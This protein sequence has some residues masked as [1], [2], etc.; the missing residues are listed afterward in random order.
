MSNLPV[1]QADHPL[2]KP[3]VLDVIKNDVFNTVNASIA[4][5]YAHLNYT[6]PP[7]ANYLVNEVTDSIIK[8]F[9]SLRMQ[10]IPL[11][12]SN[13]IRHKYGEYFGLCVVSF[14]KFI[15]GYLNSTERA[16]L[17][18]EKSKLIDEKIEPTPDEKFTTGKQLCCDLFSKF[19]MAGQLDR[20]ALAVYEFLKSVDLIDPDYKKGIYGQAMEETVHEKKSIAG[21]CMDIYKRRILN[22]EIECFEDNISKDMLTAEQHGEI[23][24][25]GRKIILKNIFNDM[26]LNEQELEPLIEM[27]R[28]V[29]IK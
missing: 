5:C 10:E 21:L 9:P 24:R 1:K 13:G 4:Q 2:L 19:K 28:N 29:L 16:E 22:A 26:I 25:T 20:T 27:K 18:K 17:V 14:E 7:D 8:N 3:S 12:F 15:T 23:Q 11:A 6:V